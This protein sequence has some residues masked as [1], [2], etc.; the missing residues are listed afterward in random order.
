MFELRSQRI[1]IAVSVLVHVLALLLYRPLARINIFSDQS[2]AAGVEVVEPLVFDLV[3]TPDDAIR[4]RPEDADHLSDKDALARDEYMDDDKTA[5]DA[6]SEG[7]TPHSV[8]AGEPETPWMDRAPSQQ[9]NAPQPDRRPLDDASGGEAGGVTGAPS[10][11]PRDEAASANRPR[12]EIP[13]AELEY[14]LRSQALR[15]PMFAHRYY[16]DDI[17]LDQRK[18]SAENLGDVSLNTY[19]WDYAWYILE[20]KRK[21]RSNTNPPAAFTLL[22]I[23]SGEA[24]VRFKVLPDGTAIDITMVD[25]NGD[26]SLA[27]TSFDAVR[28]S[29]PFRPLPADFPE[30]YLELTWTFLYHVYRHSRR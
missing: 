18:F 2:D 28:F 27:E 5:G 21:L 15:E 1:A 26:R 19:A 17:D 4:Q 16:T 9:E 8:F 20:M 10:D 13:P 24:V 22:G 11:S 25:Y 14:Y 7:L 6:Y 29:S 12:R 23:I 30:E 3:E